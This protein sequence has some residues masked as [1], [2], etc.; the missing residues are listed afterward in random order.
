MT[1]DNARSSF[2]A[3]GAA[4]FPAALEEALCREVEQGLAKYPDDVPG[5]RIASA[6]R[7]ASILDS[8]GAIGSIA[9]PVLGKGARAV[10]AVLFDK[11]AMK[12][13]GLGWHQDR[14]IVVTERTDLRDFG[15][16]TLKAGLVQVEPPFAILERMVTLRVHLDPVD[17][18]NAPL[19]IVPGSHRLGRLTQGEIDD[20]VARLGE[21]YCLAGRGDIWL[22]ATP[23]VHE[24]QAADPP[25]RRR[26]LQV[27]YSVDSLPSPLQSAGL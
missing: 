25:R 3:D 7:L 2:V 26:V 10:R 15:P 20:V 12:N 5:A 21:R 14:T 11:T 13:W 23:I 6:P 1:T 19:R 24:S 22:Y 9:A 27:D 4:H 18:T 16:W 17:A 8:S